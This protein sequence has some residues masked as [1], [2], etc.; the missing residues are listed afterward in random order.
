[1][2]N[3]GRF[4]AFAAR[5]TNLIGGD[6]NDT[7]SDVFRRDFRRSWFR[8]AD[9]DGFGTP[10]DAV[11][12]NFP[13]AGYVEL[14]T[15][16]DD[17]DPAV[18]PAA[19]EVCNGIDD[20]CDGVTDEVAWSSYCASGSSVLGCV[21]TIS[22]VGF[23]SASGT[24]GFVIQSSGLPGGHPAALIYGMGQTN[25]SWGFGSNS[26]RCVTYPW[27]RVETLGSGGTL[28]ACDGTFSTDWL[29]FM[30]THPG[31]PGQPIASGQT[32]YGQI[33][34]R[35]SGATKNSNLTAAVSFTLCP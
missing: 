12:D 27:T 13:P 1:V 8:D 24:S 6:A 20:D 5:S 15:D 35:D 28:G 3:D 17:T 4:A 23:P 16:C 7:T 11:T 2:T 31:V 18:S 32:Y 21:P 10:S 29:V 30:S 22:A 19:T 25:V 9:N 34:Y 33:W 26:V 14:D